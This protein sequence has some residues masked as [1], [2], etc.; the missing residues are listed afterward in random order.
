MVTFSFPS[1]FFNIKDSLYCGQIFR[2]KP[3][4][5]GF[6][7]FSLDKCAFCVTEG[8][9]TNITCYKQDVD[10]FTNFFDLNTDYNYIYK[11]ALSFNIP[12]L[13]RSAELGK[14][15]RIFNQDPVETLFSFIISQNNNIPRISSCIEK[16]CACFGE[17]REFLGEKYFS[18]PKVNSLANVSLDVFKSLGLGYRAQYVKKLADDIRAGFNVYA[19]S[20][21]DTNTLKLELLSILGVGNKVCD[22]VL[23]FGFKRTDSF[24]VDT[25]IY[26]LYLENFSGTLTDRVKIASFFVNLFGDYSGFIQ[27]YLFYYKRSLENS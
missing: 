21:L 3:L 12:I 14:G 5:N 13:N 8:D 11:K 23:L 1:E 26:K 10:Y 22:C 17:E 7:V 27:Q 18:F 15:V 19:L 2:F 16:L 20:S 24:P 9:L 4:N 6:L 25:W